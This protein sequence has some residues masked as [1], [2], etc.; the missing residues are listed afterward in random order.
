VPGR[1]PLG[2]LGEDGETEGQQDGRRRTFKAV[3]PP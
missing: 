1:F 3:T 2:P